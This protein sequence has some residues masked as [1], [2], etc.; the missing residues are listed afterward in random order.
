MNAAPTLSRL[1]LC[2]LVFGA[3]PAYAREVPA[4]EPF[5]DG[6]RGIAADRLTPAFWIERLREPERVVLTRSE[7][8][9]RNAKLLR[10]DPSMHDLRSLPA[11]L[12]R[13]QVAGWISG[14]ADAPT[15]PLYDEAGKPLAADALAAII[16]NRDLEA[17]PASQPTRHGLV[18]ERAAL[19][20]FPTGL[21]VFSEADDHDIDRFQESALFP[22]TPVVPLHQSRDGE[23]LFVLSPRYAAWI[24][25]DRVALGSAAEV[26][27][28]VDRA[29]YRIVTAAS[30]HTAYTPEQPALSRLQ[31]DMG[32][33]LPLH[34][35]PA[36]G[37]VNG[38]HAYASHVLELPVRRAD[39]SLAFA[40]ALLPG[41]ADSAPDYLP[42]TRANL[43]R[44]SFKFLGE[45]YGWGHA[46]DARDCSG[47]VSEVYRSMGVELPRNTR[48]QAVSPALDKRQFGA[49]DDH[50]ARLAAARALEVGDLVYIP[51]HVMMVIG[52]ID[53]APWVIHDT[54]GIGYLGADGQLERDRLN[55]VSVTP[56]L[57]L[58]ASRE[59][60]YIDRMTSIVR[61]RPNPASQAP[62]PP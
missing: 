51:G 13:E 40:P 41:S 5:T 33:R 9:A 34:E 24:A 28:Y 8:D 46:Y 21:R 23:W 31:L 26:F 61:I 19:R 55:G 16:A 60:A 6:V 36:D 37:Q 53:G 15:R 54:T 20:A 35:V 30:A 12:R 50:D 57:P 27:G 17:I 39:G 62:T 48:D 52:A 18:V 10:V 44:Q 47:F 22:G 38:Q 25:R 7:I 14:L 3:A 56:L 42:L 1:L 49:G 2:A 45:R 58:R 59:H 11:T 43:V 4:V 32:L 29:P